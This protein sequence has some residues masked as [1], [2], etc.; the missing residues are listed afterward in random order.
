MWRC[1]LYGECTRRGK[2]AQPPSV[3]SKGGGRKTEKEMD[4]A[5]V[6]RLGDYGIAASHW[7]FSWSRYEGP[8]GGVDNQCDLSMRAQLG[9]E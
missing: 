6:L 9:R 5:E 1:L 2:S 7:Q 3:I 8:I 4:E